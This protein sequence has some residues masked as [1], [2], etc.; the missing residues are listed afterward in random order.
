MSVDAAFAN[1]PS[2]STNRLLLRQIVPGDAEALFAIRSDEEGMK[3]FGHEPHAS[4]DETKDVIKLMEERYVRK[5]ALHWCITFRGEDRLIGLCSL[6]HFDEGFHC[7]ETG[8]ELNRA[9]WGKGIMTEA[10]PAILTYGFNELGLHR[11]EAVIDIENVRSKNLLLKLGFSYEGNLR[12][13]YFLRDQF[14][15]EY[16]FGLLKDEWQGSDYVFTA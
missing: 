2:F 15:D 7:A 11:I 12:Q 16:Y 5:E 13:R 3:F 10:M 9:L 1:F 6:F 4:L 8:Y 14:L